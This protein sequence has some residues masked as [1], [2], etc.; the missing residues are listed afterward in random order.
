M[1]RIEFEK[2]VTRCSFSTFLKVWCIL[3]YVINNPKQNKIRKAIKILKKV[4]I[5][6]R[7]PF[8]K[9]EVSIV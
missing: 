4:F 7:L 2:D 6:I 9:D 1:D 3:K 5:L 8:Y